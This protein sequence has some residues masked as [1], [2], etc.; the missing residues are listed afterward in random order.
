MGFRT[1][2]QVR[3]AHIDAAAI[4][5][6]PRY[7]EFLNG[8]VEDWFAAMGHD[9]HGLHVRRQLGVPTVSL[10]CDFQAPSELGDIL[11]IAIEPR[12]IGGSSCA[13]DFRMSVDGQQRISGSG[14]LVCMDLAARKAVPWPDDMRSAMN[15]FLVVA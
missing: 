5:F 15:A 11:D 14:V 2:A 7:F 12:R 4:V 8:A 3:F 13:Y 10:Q 1:K 6:Y 9:F